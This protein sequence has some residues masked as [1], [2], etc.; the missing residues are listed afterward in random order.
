MKIS[1]TLRVAKIEVEEPLLSAPFVKPPVRAVRVSLRDAVTG[2]NV[3]LNVTLEDA[4]EIHL[5]DE[6]PYT[7]GT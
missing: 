6:L 5:G 7:V 3:Y 4:R 2:V 1:G